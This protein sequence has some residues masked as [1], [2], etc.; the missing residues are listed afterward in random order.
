MARPGNIS[1]L[2]W[3]YDIPQKL[4]KKDGGNKLSVM[5]KIREWLTADWLNERP[6]KGTHGRHYPFWWFVCQ[7]SESKDSMVYWL[8]LLMQ[9]CFRVRQTALIPHISLQGSFHM[10]RVGYI[11]QAQGWWI[12]YGCVGGHLTL[13]FVYPTQLWS[14]WVLP[15]YP[16]HSSN[17]VSYK[18][19]PIHIM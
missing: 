11:K 15:I 17:D 4:G 12:H 8:L 19:K 7:P 1:W 5:W 6:V 16:H 18:H 2:R 10:W 13:R 3:V 14:A 9:A